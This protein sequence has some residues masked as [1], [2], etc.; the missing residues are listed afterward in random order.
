LCE[1]DKAVAAYEAILGEDNAEAEAH[2]GVVLSRYGIEYVEDPGS[3][4]RIPTCHRVQVESVLLDAEY[5][6]ALEH[7][8]DAGARAYYQEQGKRIAEIQRDILAVSAQEASYDVFV[9]Y[10]ESTEGGSRTPDSVL[11]QE[12]HQHL[13]EK[14]MRVFYARI[15]LEEHA[16]QKYEPYIYG[17]LTSAR[18][19]VVVGTKAEHFNA[20]W[21]RNE[22]SR[23]LQ[24]RRKDRGKVL[25][26]CYKGMDA[27]E[28]P[29]ELAEL[30]S[31]DMGR[32]G[33]MQ[34]MVRGVEK[35]LGRDRTKTVDKA[36]SSTASNETAGWLKRAWIFLEDEDFVAA[37]EYAERVL[38]RDP[39]TGEA[40]W[41]KALAGLSLKRESDVIER[42]QSLVS[43]GNYQKAA[44][45]GSP[46]LRQRLAGFEVAIQKRIEDE[47]RR[48]EVE[49]LR[50][51]EQVRERERLAEENRK[52]QES[53]R[54]A[55]EVIEA[56]KRARLEAEER[57]RHQSILAQVR[58]LVANGYLKEASKLYEGLK[59]RLSGLDYQGVELALNQALSQV[60]RM[61]SGLKEAI[62]VLQDAA[63]GSRGF[64]VF[65]PFAHR[66]KCRSACG[67]AATAMDGAVQY[68]ATKGGSSGEALG[69]LLE[70]ARELD[71][72]V[73]YAVVRAGRMVKV[74][75]VVWA[76]VVT[77]GGLI[78]QQYLAIQERERQRLA[79][80]ARAAEEKE[81]AEA[82]VKAEAEEGERQ[83]LAAEAKAAEE[84]ALAKAKAKVEAAETAFASK[85]GLSKPFVAGVRGQAGDLAVRWIPSGRFTM[86]SPSSEPDR[87]SDEVQ[88][89][90][91]LTRGFFLAE[92]ECTQGQWASVMGGNPSRFKGPDRPVEQVSWGEA[93]EYCRRLTAK[94]RA[95]GILAEGW[96]WR[97]PTEA[98]WEYAARAGTKGARYGELDAIAWY[99]GNSGSETHAVGQ[100]AANA[101]GLQ[102]MMGNVWEWCSDW[103]GDY[104]TGSETNPTGPSSG[105]DRVNRGGSWSG[106]ARYARS[107]N[108][109]RLVPGARY[110]NLGFRPALSSVR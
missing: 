96:E 20:V 61:E 8:P 105:S 72:Q 11:A 89:E 83:R 6:M 34:D 86:G 58:E 29:Q 14:G 15:S 3:G 53:E 54:V 60:T 5:L 87:Y 42:Q 50:A 19:M 17:A 75:G 57:D 22:W 9:C 56:E 82:K 21:V 55:R 13:T 65:P 51:Q 80:E 78:F 37:S 2:W 70:T 99:D 91:V 46:D 77:T 25:I 97:L 104:A 93:V 66:H 26:P 109:Y 84:K 85:L 23:F 16:G 95:E 31:Q 18:V 35:V 88:L 48:K 69:E 98:E 33:F 4:E 107:A 39:E 108:R 10:K 106:D 38:D 28:L 63:S 41:V 47:K 94:Q 59:K 30:Q 45:Y 7:A 44:R 43:N 101:W 27:Y 49:R 52:R 90:A 67:V 1:F 40:Y 103:S 73:G 36:S 24:L 71:Q 68:L 32:L 12:I 74:L 62:S 64:V 100:K 81:L 102:D 76:I 79:A 92:T 110:N